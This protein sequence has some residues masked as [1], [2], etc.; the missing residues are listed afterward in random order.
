MITKQRIKTILSPATTFLKYRVLHV[1]DSTHRIALGVALG[2]FIAYMP[3]LG[4]H[5]VLAVLLSVILRAN[6]F[7]ALT[8]VW[9]SNPFTFILLYYPNYLLGRKI[10]AHLGLQEQLGTAEVASLLRESL[11]FGYVFTGFFTTEF[12][13][14]IGSLIAKMGLEMFVGGLVFG[15]AIAVTAYFVTY[16]L[17]GRYR[18]KEFADS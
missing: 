2:L 7:V 14:Q 16:R 3:P 15:S 4:F 11:S 1:D 6:K 5:I 8:F 9:V 10:L 12:W 17:V 18:R 13:R